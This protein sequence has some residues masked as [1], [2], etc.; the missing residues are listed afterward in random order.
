MNTLEVM[1]FF[2]L[3]KRGINWRM[4]EIVFKKD[5]ESIK[6]LIV[7]SGHYKSTKNISD[8]DKYQRVF[9]EIDL[10]SR[11]MQF[12]D[13]VYLVETG[14]F[15][16]DEGIKKIK[17]LPH[18]IEIAIPEF[19][20]SELEK[21]SDND[22]RAASALH[23]IQTRDFSIIPKQNYKLRNRPQYFKNARSLGIVEAACILSE[24][25][26][27]VKIFTTSGEVVKVAQMQ[28]NSDISVFKF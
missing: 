28:H 11:K 5:R 22:Y 9:D 20:L 21:I 8:Y 14:M 23:L 17:R 16:N 25:D 26:C 13:E 7:G 24:R 2:F 19:C 12:T 15:L 6:K 27:K 18:F 4:M 1:V 10:N 3:A